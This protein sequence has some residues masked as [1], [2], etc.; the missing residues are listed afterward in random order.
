[1]EDYL[2]VYQPSPPWETSFPALA[3]NEENFVTSNL[4]EDEEHIA[5][6]RRKVDEHKVQRHPAILRTSRKI[7]NDASTLLY[8]SLE[9]EVRPCDV[10]F[11]SFWD[12]VVELSDGIWR[13]RPSQLGAKNSTKR[14]E[15]KGFNLGGIMDHY[16]FTK[17]ERLF[18][19]AKLHCVNKRAAPL[20]SELIRQR[21]FSTRVAKT[22]LRSMYVSKGRA[23]FSHLSQTSSNCSSMSWCN[24]PTSVAFISVSRLK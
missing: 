7:Y 8:P 20:F 5:E 17:F 13:F 11:T 23:M 6:C 1:M 19:N 22:K 4:P 9:I 10:I 3:T 2:I 12:P 15:N 18:F 14:P 21:Q 24:L 16:V